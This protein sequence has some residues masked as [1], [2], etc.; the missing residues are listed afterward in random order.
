MVSA[1]SLMLKSRLY[2]Q[3]HFVGS[4]E[5]FVAFD[6]VGSVDA[7]AEQ[8]AGKSAFRVAV[9]PSCEAAFRAFRHFGFVFGCCCQQIN[10]AELVAKGYI[11]FMR[12]IITFI[13][14][15]IS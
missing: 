1:V 5:F 13:W 9:G 15:L 7:A 4:L 6:G 14:P 10:V 2:V 11:A 3:S 8:C 12:S